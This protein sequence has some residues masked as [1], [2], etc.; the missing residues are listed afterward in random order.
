MGPTKGTFSGASDK[1]N[2][3]RYISLLLDFER[4]QK[5]AIGEMLMSRLVIKS[6]PIVRNTANIADKG[7]R[8]NNSE[9]PRNYSF[10]WDDRCSIAKAK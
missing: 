3:K 9:T 6:L 8:F 4:K 10:L 1:K 2:D 7:N 5:T